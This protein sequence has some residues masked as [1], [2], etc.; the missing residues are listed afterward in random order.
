MARSDEARLPQADAGAEFQRLVDI[1][2]KLRGTDG[3]PWDREQTLESLRPF[4]LEETYEVMEAIDRA[5]HDELRGEIGDFLFEGVF[6]AQVETDEGRFTVT[7]SLRRINEKLI[8][9]H[10]HIVGDAAGVDTPGKVVEQW[11]QIKAREQLTAGERQS[12]L[13]GLA[14]AL[15]ALLRAH[16]IG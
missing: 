7:D 14:R 10:P 4:V 11:E 9:R 5:D 15:P 6:L 3:C 8:R 13:K 16:E 2:A 1:M 12:L